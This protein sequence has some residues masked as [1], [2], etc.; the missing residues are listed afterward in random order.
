MAGNIVI[1][2]TLT[3]TPGDLAMVSAALPDHIRLTRAEPG[4]ISFSITPSPDTPCQ[5]DIAERFVNRA[6]FDSHSARTKASDWWEK[7]SHISRNIKVTEK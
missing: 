6:A 1:T 2:G 5:F 4:C 7:S 3:C